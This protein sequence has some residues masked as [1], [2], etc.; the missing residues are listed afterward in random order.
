MGKK[1][2]S[3]QGHSLRYSALAHRRADKKR[4]RLI[5]KRLS[6]LNETTFKS[7]NRQKSWDVVVDAEVGDIKRVF[8]VGTVK[9]APFKA[10]DMPTWDT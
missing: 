10:G 6:R 5:K 8:D 2:F 9:E 7:T 4:G 1:K 3:K